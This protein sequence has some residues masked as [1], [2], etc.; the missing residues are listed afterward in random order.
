M[1]ILD[2]N[3]AEAKKVAQDKDVK[4]RDGTQPKKYFDKKGDDKLA[5]STKQD[6]ARHFEKGASKDDDDSSAYEPAPGDAEAETK[7]SKHTKKFKKMFGEDAVAAARLKANQADE[8]ER[9]KDKHEREVE[10]LKQKHEKENEK[11]K[12]EDEKEKENEL[13]QKQREAQREEV[14]IEE[15][16]AA[17]KSLKKKA[18]KTGISVGILKQVYKRGVAAWRTGHRPGTTP[19]QWGHARVNSF[20][21]KGEGTWGKADKD[22]ADKVRGESIEERYADR[23]REKTKSQQKAHQKAMMKIARKSIK[24]YDKRNKKEEIEEGKLVTDWRSILEYI[25]KNIMKMVEKEYEKNPEKGLGMINQLGSYVKMKVTDKKQEK[26]KL[27]L[28]FGDELEEVFLPYSQPWND[29]KGLHQTLGLLKDTKS[30]KNA[31]KVIEKLAKKHKVE[32]EVDGRGQKQFVYLTS[33][34]KNAIDKLKKDLMKNTKLV[35]ALDTVNGTFKEEMMPGK[36]NVSDDGVCELGTD[37]IRK[38]YQADTPGQSEEAYIKETEKAFHEQQERAKKN[39][40]DVFGNPLKGYPANEEFEV[41][42]K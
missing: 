22:L 6:R 9:Q 33:F 31:A 16:S 4:S 7:P 36:G 8:T 30:R 39:F 2:Q 42:D 23:Q 17:D 28:K 34:D 5:K 21:T 11:Q 1:D 10:K 25:F 12:A 24:D 14:E 3:I 27:F 41:I 15:E 29:K 32:F 40:K 38:K 26:G 18:D 13:M 20:I 37:D 35:K 19:E